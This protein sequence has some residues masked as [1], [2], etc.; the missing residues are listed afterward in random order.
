MRPLSSYRIRTSAVNQERPSSRLTSASNN[1]SNKSSRVNTSEKSDS[2]E[3]ISDI[4]I[5]SSCLTVGPTLQGNPL[6]ALLARKRPNSSNFINETKCEQD[7]TSTK[8][9]LDEAIKKLE[10][11]ESNLKNKELKSE[12]LN[13][14]KDH[15]KKLEERKHYFEPQ[16]LRIEDNYD[17][18]DARILSDNDETTNYNYYDEYHEIRNITNDDTSN[19]LNNLISPRLQ[20]ASRSKPNELI[21]S[22][23]EPLLVKEKRSKSRQRSKSRSGQIK[24]SIDD[25]L[26]VPINRSINRE[27]SD[28]SSRI[29]TGDTGYASFS[30]ISVSSL[31]SITDRLTQNSHQPTIVSSHLGS[32]LV[33]TP[34]LVQPPH[35]QTSLTKG[36]SLNT[37]KQ[38]KTNLMPL[39]SS[40]LQ[41][42]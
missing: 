38:L 37:L 32:S 31:S 36:S 18:T 14:K 3:Q 35:S 23:D 5:D 41:K 10:I 22:S 27:D 15:A 16:V 7:K 8:V 24:R 1:N 9:N 25:D 13:W 40:Y 20:S 6:K 11:D 28:L 17:E 19:E 4:L 29:E 39:S 2:P 34:L 42:K 12:L 33:K 26:L 21:V 30:S